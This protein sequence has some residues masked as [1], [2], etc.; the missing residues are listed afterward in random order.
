MAYS[1]VSA[2]NPKALLGAL[3]TFATAQGWTIEYDHANG[4]G[5]SFG[6][7]IALSTPSGSCHVAIGEQTATQNPIAVSGALGADTDGRIYMALANSIQLSP[8]LIQYWGHP[9]SPVVGS[10]D[11]VRV[12]VN[13]IWGPMDEVHLFG[14]DTYILVAVKCD[15]LRYTAFGFGEVDDKGMGLSPKPAFAFA[16]YQPFWNTNRTT[17]YQNASLAEGNSYLGTPSP[18]ANSCLVRVP[19]GL[20]DTGQGFLTGNLY[21]PMGFGSV[22]HTLQYLW[23]RQDYPEQGLTGNSDG[24]FYNDHGLWLRNAPTT[25]GVP[26]WSMPLIYQDT[27]LNLSSY[28]GDIPGFRMC[29]MI[30]MVSSQ[31]ITYGGEVH[32][33]FPWKQKGTPEDAGFGG[34]YNNQPNSFDMAWAFLKN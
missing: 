15:A 7:Q 34:T 23:K 3:I 6:G 21:A 19:S 5:S 9:G 20:L 16:N 18:A 11:N 4:T 10:T 33:I 22:R 31:E 1:L 28:L 30:G 25:G 17:V 27:T 2:A 24:T 32:K 12:L 13:D 29:R 14:D 26:L 8:S